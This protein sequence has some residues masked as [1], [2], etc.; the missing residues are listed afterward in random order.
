MTVRAIATDHSLDELV[1][2]VN[3]RAHIGGDHMPS[4][5]ADIARDFLIELGMNVEQTN[6]DAA[7]TA[8]TELMEAIVQIYSAA[9]MD[10][11]RRAYPYII[12]W[13]RRMRSNASFIDDE[14]RAAMH[15]GAPTGAYCHSGGKWLT[16][17]E[18]P[19]SVLTNVMKYLP[20]FAS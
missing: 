2:E 19:P 13:G 4:D 8:M 18:L 1:R 6:H 15:D 20:T 14:V 3:Q 9:Q 16:I 17:A 5:A 10:K 11:A 7:Y 12:A